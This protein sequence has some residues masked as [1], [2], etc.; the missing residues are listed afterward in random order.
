[1]TA[2]LEQNWT[3]CETSKIKTQ[4]SKS[5]WMN[6]L[7]KLSSVSLITILERRIRKSNFS[8]LTAKLMLTAKSTTTNQSQI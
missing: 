8:M 5:I 3:S 2:L 7:I 6:W 4:L 1:M